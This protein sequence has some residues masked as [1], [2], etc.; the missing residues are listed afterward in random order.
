MYAMRKSPTVQ[1]FGVRI[2][3]LDDAELE[4]LV[5]RAGAFIAQFGVGGDHADCIHTVQK[6]F[7]LR[8]EDLE[9]GR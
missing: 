6:L 2:F 1:Y 4:A 8:C 3:A 9:I 5:G 7:A